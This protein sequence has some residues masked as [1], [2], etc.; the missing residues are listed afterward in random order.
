VLWS[1]SAGRLA[2]GS[3]SQISGKVN[4]YVSANF[5]FSAGVSK[6]TPRITAFLWS[7]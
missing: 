2:A 5:R 7:Y 3:V 1:W 4:A 6:D